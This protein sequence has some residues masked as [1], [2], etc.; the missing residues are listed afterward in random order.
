M[1]DYA[2]SGRCRHLLILD[3]FGEPTTERCEAC[4]NCLGEAAPAGDAADAGLREIIATLRDEFASRYGRDPADIMGPKTVRE[5]A[6]YRP[7]DRGELLETWGIAEIKVDW[8]GAEVLRAIADWEEANP[9]APARPERTGRRQPRLVD[10]ELLPVDEALYGRLSAWRLERS[11]RDAVPAYVVFSNKTL[12][13]IA[14]LRPR[15]LRALAGVWGVGSSRV[16]RHGDEV[17]AVLNAG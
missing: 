7:R 11:Q 6:T 17:L 13:E 12:R 9:D 5:L 4:N 1:V 15:D 8:F 3:Y 10:A 2:E 14:A 16:A